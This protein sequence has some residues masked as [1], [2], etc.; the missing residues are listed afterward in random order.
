YDYTPFAE[1]P[2]PASLATILAGLSLLG[3]VRRRARHK[4]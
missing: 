2:E 3:A 4:A 1:V